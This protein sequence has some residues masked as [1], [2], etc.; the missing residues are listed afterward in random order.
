MLQ[1][2]TWGPRDPQAL[3]PVSSL[4][5][6]E[7]TY[8]LGLGFPTCKTRGVVWGQRVCAACLSACLQW[9]PGV[10]V[11]SFHPGVG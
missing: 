9:G 3:G 11:V 6:A 4:D 10:A 7:G 8:P 2:Q 5:L 1:G